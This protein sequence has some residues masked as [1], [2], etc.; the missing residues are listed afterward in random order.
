MK[1]NDLVLPFIWGVHRHNSFWDQPEQLIPERF[2]SDNSANRDRWAYL[3]FAAGTRICIGKSLALT[4]LLVHTS[5]LLQNVRLEVISEDTPAKV[6]MTL[7][8]N[9]PV[10]ARVT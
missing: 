10:N 7:R 6:S 4:E 2:S 3:P 9:N 8:P 1:P 5:L